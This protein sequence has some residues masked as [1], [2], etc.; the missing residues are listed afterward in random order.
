MVACL[1]LELAQGLGKVPMF[2]VCFMFK[3]MAVVGDRVEGMP[4]H[5]VAKRA[6]HT[7][8]PHNNVVSCHGV[9]HI[10]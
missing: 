7:A 5:G 10:E 8:A 4:A 2:E 6:P 9:G 1:S 3:C